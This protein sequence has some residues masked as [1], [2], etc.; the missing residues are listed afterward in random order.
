ME[1]FK[2]FSALHSCHFLT[3]L[4]HWL[5][6]ASVVGASVVSLSDAIRAVVTMES[7]LAFLS[8]VVPSLSEIF[9]VLHIA[10]RI[11]RMCSC[12]TC[13]DFTPKLEPKEGS[14]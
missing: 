2:S 8:A 5:T 1:N 9:V 11:N 10:L 13:K 6:F 14:V 4:L 12:D 3:D 7:M